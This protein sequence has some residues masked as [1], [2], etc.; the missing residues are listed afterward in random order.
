MVWIVEWDGGQR[1]FYSLT[2]AADFIG[3]QRWRLC[4]YE[5]NDFIRVNGYIIYRKNED[6]LRGRWAKL[7]ERLI[8][9]N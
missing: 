5:R 4:G 8:G 6:S 3:I 9:V 2:A 7:Q 1:K